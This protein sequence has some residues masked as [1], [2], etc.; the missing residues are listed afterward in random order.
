MFEHS[1]I[2]YNDL[3]DYNTGEIPILSL[4]SLCLINLLDA[5]K[6]GVCGRPGVHHDE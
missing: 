1:A 4:V 5:D 6:D 3:H 2:Y